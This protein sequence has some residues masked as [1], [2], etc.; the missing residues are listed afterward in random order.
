MNLDKVTQNS[1]LH[2]QMV[3]FEDAYTS[4]LSEPVSQTESNH[5]FLQNYTAKF[6]S[7]SKFI[8]IKLYNQIN[9]KLL[10]RKKKIK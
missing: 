10:K 5:I 3:Q 9:G 8:N 4:Q 1:T 7:K 6:E 2:K